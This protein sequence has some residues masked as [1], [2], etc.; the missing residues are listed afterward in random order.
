LVEEARCHVERMT[1]TLFNLGILTE[2][3]FD[4]QVSGAVWLNDTGRKK[5]LTKWQ[6]KKRSDLMHPYL[7]QKI[8]FGLLP[9][10]QS[11]LLAK[12]IRGELNEYPC[13][14]NR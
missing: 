9:Y 12:Y 6:E 10:I 11:N 4:M 7:K 8:Q 1:I 14:L 5:V 2:K 13:Y 3:D